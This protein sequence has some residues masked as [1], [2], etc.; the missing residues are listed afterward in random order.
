MRAIRSAVLIFLAMFAATA[1]VGAQRGGGGGSP[2]ATLHYDGGGAVPPNTTFYVDYQQ[3]VLSLCG[4][5]AITDTMVTHTRQYNGSWDNVALADGALANCPSGVSGQGYYIELFNLLPGNNSI[6]VTANGSGGSLSAQFNINYMPP[7][8]A[9]VGILSPTMSIVPSGLATVPMTIT[10]IGASTGRFSIVV[11]CTGPLVNCGKSAGGASTFLTSYLSSQASEVIDL[12][13]IGDNYA[14]VGSIQV[15]ATPELSS[16]YGDTASG[17]ITVVA[18]P[19]LPLTVARGVASQAA[20]VSTMHPLRFTISNP[21]P[22]LTRVVTAYTTCTNGMSCAISPA[23]ASYIL[24][25]GRDTTITVN[26]TRPG[27]T[28]PGGTYVKLSA[29]SSGPY[30]ASAD[31]TLV[32]TGTAPS[33][34]ATVSVVGNPG[35]SIARDQ[36]LSLSLA[37]A[38][39]AECGALRVA[40]GFPGVR[41]MGVERAPSLLYLSDH[42]LAFTRI[43]ATV[44][45]AYSASTPASMNATLAIAGQPAIPARTYTWAPVCFTEA[46]CRIVFPLTTTLA[47]GEY[48]YTLTIA[49]NTGGSFQTTGKLVIVNRSASAF[50]G[51]WWMGGLEILKPGTASTR[52]LWVGGDG[53][54]R[55]FVRQN[56]PADTLYWIADNPVSRVDTLKRITG[57]WERR[58]PNKARVEFDATFRHTKTVNRQGHTTRFGYAGARAVPDTLHLPIPSGGSGRS[59]RFVY[60]GSAGVERL[61]TIVAPNGSGGTH[62]TTVDVDANFRL[63]RITAPFDSTATDTVRFGYATGTSRLL[64]KRYSRMNDSVG[65]V[66]D[67]A[68]TV[69]SAT[70]YSGLAGGSEPNAVIALCAAES[71][72]LTTCGLDAE[73]AIPLSYLR[74]TTL[75]NGA[76]TDVLDRMI[77]QVGRFGAPDS[78]V[79][80]IGNWT[81]IKRQHGTFPALVTETR[82]PAGLVTTMTYNTRGLPTQSQVVAPY[83]GSDAITTMTWHPTFDVVTKTVA[84]TGEV[85]TLAYDAYG[86]RTWQQRGTHDSTRVYFYYDTY[87]R[88][89][90]IKPSA[91]PAGKLAARFVYDGA[92]GN[93]WKSLSALG[94]TTEALQDYIGRDTLVYSPTDSAQ[95]S[96][97]R[98]KEH[99]GLD[100]YGRA[101]K[102]TTTGAAQSGTLSWGGE[103]VSLAAPERVSVV[104]TR[105]DKEGR[106]TR[107]TRYMP[108]D[109]S[110]T[111]LG[112]T[113][114]VYDRLGRLRSKEEMWTTG[115]DSM[116][117]NAAGLLTE[118]RS[119]NGDTLRTTYDVLNRPMTR[120]AS[121][122]QFAKVPCLECHNTISHP[123]IGDTTKAPFYGSKTAPNVGVP[124]I[125][126]PQ[127][128]VVFGY[129][130]AGRM[131]QADNQEAKVRRGYYPNGALK[132][133]TSHIRNYD[134]FY[135]FG[136][137]T[138]SLEY[139]YDLSGRRLTRKDNVTG[140]TTATQKYAYDALGQLASTTD[141]LHS[142]AKVSATFS[143]DALGR[144]LSQSVPAASTSAAW[145]YDIEGRP[146]T[147]SEEIFADTMRYDARGKRI[148]VAGQALMDGLNHGAALMAYD[149]LGQLVASV[150]N[151]RE[152]KTTGAFSLD[153]LG[154]VRV[155]HANRLE[156]G[157][158]NAEQLDSSSYQGSRLLSKVGTFYPENRNSTHDPAT[159]IIDSLIVQYDNAGNV[160]H[161]QL[162]KREW[163]TSTTSERA[164]SGHHWSWNYY[165]ANNRLRYAQRT[166]YASAGKETVFEDYWYDALGRRVAVRTRADSLTCLAGVKTG[167]CLQTYMRTV[168]DGD[169]I[170]AEDR[171]E[172]EWSSADAAV[173]SAPSIPPSNPSL[174]EHYG[175]VRYMQTGAIDAPIAVWKDGAARVLHRNWRGNVAGATFV[176]TGLLDNTTVWP[177]AYTDEWLRPDANQ[178]LP[179]PNRWLGSLVV[180]QRDA[181]GTLYRRNRYYDPTSGRFTQEDPIGLA[182]GM[183]LYGYAAGDP[184]NNA[185][186]F[187]LNPCIVAPQV[188]IAIVVAGARA[189]SAAAKAPAVQRG[190]QRAV[191]LGKAGEA[192]VSQ[193]LGD[194]AK[195]S[196]AVE[197]MRGRIPDFIDRVNN[198]FHEVKNVN[199]QYYSRQ[200]RDMADGA[201]ELGAKLTIWLRDPKAVSAPL[202]EA[203]EQGKVILEKIP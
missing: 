60:T 98:M 62:S 1:E 193:A 2:S 3:F 172:G 199:Y 70:S 182:G 43:V 187:G 16:V 136:A 195:N 129:D 158:P 59:F 128:V 112:Q 133:D 46:G 198:A 82:D 71:R 51:G 42:A 76:R 155:S 116:I 134:A 147:R 190:L 171:G 170:L 9:Q 92:L 58:L 68:Y 23:V 93:V 145:T 14:G 142:G 31:S 135:Q 174:A 77:F 149:G 140:F 114:F 115:R 65:F 143:Y 96:G 94:F 4:L 49:P 80:A 56:L 72:S 67:S 151:D 138:S 197:A 200:L 55:V 168:W 101:R 100:H 203:A 148:A 104:W 177:A 45:V 37:A 107:V 102:V 132:A 191:D 6:S 73:P 161:Q 22:L 86:N 11:S 103:S 97:Q 7:Y 110:P 194:L 157:W 21:D 36:C 26:P 183:N 38:S 131:T 47:T 41:T 169:Q 111:V 164:L 87:H 12:R 120:T 90:S 196:R 91:L 29:S 85:D 175:K 109:G 75:L 84:P 146:L 121:A 202:Q 25:P 125:I 54:S 156:A 113:D 186:P 88:L 69:T 192:R 33:F 139:T 10:N 81:R 141:S 74:A 188:C 28:L 18:P 173:G 124:Q 99:F 159:E 89:D 117:Y 50:G 176:A 181:T 79:D 64:T 66:Y 126:I 30:S 163:E 127:E 150:N 118:S 152:H 179:T 184:I 48:D 178:T 165:D 34:T 32:T 13:A 153:A 44:S 40:H 35:T 160:T 130:L 122:K 137:F 154:N 27:S 24:A 52:M 57:G 123:V 201:Q 144:L 53:S 17:S 8:Q 20:P 5:G 185:D 167:H 106:S 95:T 19:T 39:G 78:I 63:T 189:A 105:F 162:I 83:G 15:I 108:P 180:D 119:R 61:T 166:N